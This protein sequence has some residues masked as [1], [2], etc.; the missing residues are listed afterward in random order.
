MAAP[1]VPAKARQE[2]LKRTPVVERVLGE[3]GKVE[4]N[5]THIFAAMFEALSEIVSDQEARIS[6]LE[7]Q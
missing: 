4:T 6:E 7:S 3:P 1:R 2:A 5:S